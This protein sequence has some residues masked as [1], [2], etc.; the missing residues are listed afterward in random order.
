MTYGTYDRR[1]LRPKTSASIH[2]IPPAVVPNVILVAVPI[3]VNAAIFP[4]SLVVARVFVALL[5]GAFALV[6]RH[7][8]G[9]ITRASTDRGAFQ[10]VFA[11]SVDESADRG[12]RGGARGLS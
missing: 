7:A 10:R 6:A 2:V 1:E 5:V 8:S 12:A 4:V 9:E 3:A 11:A